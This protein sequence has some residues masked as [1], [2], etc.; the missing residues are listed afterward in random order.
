M[1]RMKT[2]AFTGVASRDLSRHLRA[3]GMKVVDIA[4]NDGLSTMQVRTDKT[5]DQLQAL[6]QQLQ[7][8]QAVV[9]DVNR[10]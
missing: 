10:V 5:G 1:S 9:Q 7:G 6:A 2:V 4:T 8:C 3:N